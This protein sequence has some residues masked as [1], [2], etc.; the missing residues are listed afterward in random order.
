MCKVKCACGWI[1]TAANSKA[2]GEALKDHWAYL[3]HDV[4]EA[5]SV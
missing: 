1:V 2:A 3:K 5:E 4:M